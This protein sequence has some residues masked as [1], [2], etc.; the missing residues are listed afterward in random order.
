MRHSCRPL[1]PSV[2]A[3]AIAAVCV[4]A[5]ADDAPDTI[6]VTATRL[7]AP[8]FDVPASISTVS[9]D[10][11]ADTALGVNLSEVLPAVPGLLARDRQNYAQD[12]QISV[13]GFGA[14]STFGVRGVRLYLDGIPATQPDG[15]GQVSHFNL[16]SADR[17]EVL[18]GPFSTLYGNSSGGV[19]QLFTA[20]GSAQ[21]ELFGGVAL[22]SYGT[23]RG[24]VG[25]SGRLGIADYNFDYLHFTTDGVRDHSAA[26]RDSFNGK[27]GLDFSDGGKL[28]LLLNYFNSP[29]AQDPL[30]LTRD[31]FEADPRQATAVATQY[32][33]RKSAD[34][35]QIGAIYD[36]ALSPAQALR[37][38]VYGGHR[39]VEQFLSIPP[40]AQANPRHS[41]GVV[42]L[43]TGY[44]GGDLRWSWHGALARQ[45]LEVIA[46]LSYDALAQQRRGYENFVGDTLGVRGALRRDENDDVHDF[47]QYL[48]ANWDFAERWSLLAG[49]RHS[50]V[51]FKSEDHYI[52]SSNPDDSGSTHYG[53]TTPVAGLS[54]HY[55]PTLNLYAAYGQ[56]FETP[57]FAELAYRPDGQAGL[58][59]D[60]DAARSDN[61]EIGAKWHPRQRVQTEL[62]LF[63]TL[64][65]DELV[66]ATNSG[67]R[68]TYDNAGRTR[69]RGIE[70]SALA[71]L[72]HDFKLQ[73]AYT[74]LDATTRAAY[75]T[76]TG[77]PC[78]QP[79]NSNPSGTNLGTVAAGS[80]IPG[81]PES[82]L[83]AE[84]R[85]GRD[86]GWN[87]ALDGRYVS[88]VQ[89]NDI[90]SEAAPSYGLLDAS[91]GYVFDLPT[92]RVRSFVRVDNLLDRDYV[93]SVIVNDGNGR[94]YEPGPGRS[95]LAGLRLEWKY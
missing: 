33:T 58:N 68:S 88:K 91:A 3:I 82:N 93:G 36:C 20:D 50:K 26:T 46:G 15:Q 32:D 67:G 78:A 14:R 40:S 95:V 84:L 42:D 44:G 51:R 4:H 90:D 5:A 2:L 61:A 7:P 21:P 25:A 31:Q 94:Y 86:S 56:G 34:Q 8:S 17:V 12:T 77:S 63:Q 65:R 35:K 73:L 41:G 66:T 92:L 10:E 52:T 85:W 87:A 83:Y 24:D 80:R 59:F 81:V 1:P 55:S 45:P 30:G 19:I 76:C 22:G 60:L 74:L 57:T 29:H 48:Q 6:T 16:E 43:G 89:V 28:T 23:R 75:T 79:S 37:V 39:N 71:R 9:S 11:L 69:R 70:A 18:R 38:L 72:P 64:T 27:L 47:D 53:A 49:L 54:F 62:A 13:R